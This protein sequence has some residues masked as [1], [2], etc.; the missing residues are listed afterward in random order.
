MDAIISLF[1]ILF[2]SYSLSLLFNK[3]NIPKLLAPIILGLI[4]SSTNFY[5]GKEAL[6]SITFIKDIAIIFLM[7]FVGLKINLK[8]FFKSSKK[9][10]LIAT[11]ASL[12]PFFFGFFG[13]Q[14][15]YK[16]GFL[17]YFIFNSNNLLIISYIV[18]ICLSVTAEVVLIEILEEL[19]ILKSSIGETIIESGLVDTIIGVLLL[20]GVVMFLPTS[21]YHSF[22]IPLKITIRIFEILIFT[23]LLYL[24]GKFILP[25]LMKEIESNKSKDIDYFTLS[26]IITL[27]LAVLSTQ[28]D[29]GG[30]ILGAIFSGIIIKHT[31]LKGDKL[32][33]KEEHHLTKIIEITTFG[34][35]APFFLFWI[36]LNSNLEVLFLNPFLSIFL[37]I[38]AFSGKF[39]G[40]YL[41]N[42][43]AKG[44]KKEGIIIGFGMNT[45]GE[46]D[47]MVATLIY[48][49]GF[50][51]KEL[52][53]SLIF[54][55]LI[56]TLISPIFFKYLIKKHNKS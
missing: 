43:L 6:F 12:L 55:S 22:S 50:F 48:S 45:K 38:L 19:Q 53:S 13:I 16:L 9:S 51:G 56:T 35:F 23:L 10:I 47:I 34:F 14:I 29:F 1:L 39:L 41:G 21:S 32:E 44:N 7:F 49:L 17:N 30:S 26:I 5:I 31:L 2:L 11:F 42:F 25:K 46:V 18:G 20:T 3:I 8:H 54:M 37:I 40:S 52:F 15:A 33:I 4:F 24:L 27:F 36:G 28:F